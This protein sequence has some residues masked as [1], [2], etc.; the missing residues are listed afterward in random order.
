MQTINIWMQMLG[1]NRDDPDRGVA[2]YLETTGFTPASIC[3]LLYHPD[4]VNLHRGMDEEY[5]LFQ[6]N[7]AYHGIPRNKERERQ[8]W[9]N[10]D[11]RQLIA[12]LKKK[13]IDFY[14]GIMG[15]YCAD[16]YHHEWLSDHPEVRCMAR[17]GDGALFCLKRLKDGSYYEDFF[18]EKLVQTLVDYDCAGVHLA[19]NF[20]PAGRPCVADYSCDMVGQFIDHTGIRLPDEVMATMQSNELADRC[21]RADYIW[22]NLREEWLAFYEWRWERFFQKVCAAV[23]AVGKKVWVLGMYCTDP[24]ETRYIYGFNSKRVMDAGVDCMTANILPTSVA[25]N[26]PDR[27]YYFHRYH[28]DLPMLRAQV[29]EDHSIVTMVGVQDASEEWSVL[30]HQPVKLERDIYTMTAFQSPVK[31][32]GLKPATD[33]LFLCLGDGIPHD[34]WQFLKS[35]MDTGLG[36]DAERSWSPMV[37]WSDTADDRTIGEYIRTRR[38][39][40]HRQSFEIFK[41]GTPF[42]GAV[43]SDM[44]DGF[45]G[46]LFVPN[47]DLLSDDEQKMLAAANFPWVGTVPQGFD[48]AACGIEPVLSCTD[49]FSDYPMTAFMV[50]DGLTDALKAEVA[51]LCAEDDG[52][53]STGDLP[54]ADNYPLRSMLPFRKLTTGFVKAC[55]AMLR[56]AMFTQFPVTA[57]EPMMALRLK[58]GRDRLFLYNADDGHYVHVVVTSGEDIR[59]ADIVTPYPVLPVRWVSEK[60]TGF[61]FNYNASRT[62]MRKFQMKMAPSGVNIVDI[63]RMK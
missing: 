22:A 18:A 48:L 3:A 59:S 43:R 56:A 11:L 12:E 5:T 47:F 52:K 7:C 27:E 34:R 15:S 14:A 20:C 39:S 41:Q 40:A 44:L 24:F 46:V 42:G 49:G 54:E 38:T 45:E 16:R 62:E 51:A 36:V 9:T 55:G 28:M 58:N 33:G 57:S 6:D 50:G 53:P 60:N 61:G 29:G 4:F 19:D 26:F 1:F 37:L 31:A 8:P 23:H 25:M 21:I 17:D 30:D 35:R 10:Y 32:G 13:G 63:D 2:R